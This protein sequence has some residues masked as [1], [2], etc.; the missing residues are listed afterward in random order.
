[1]KEV[2]RGKSVRPANLNEN[3]EWFD[4]NPLCDRQLGLI[5]F[6]LFVLFQVVLVA[7]LDGAFHGIDWV[8][9]MVPYYVFE[10]AEVTP[11]Y[12]IYTTNTYTCGI[13]NNKHLNTH[14]FTQCTKQHIF[15][16]TLMFVHNIRAHKNAHILMTFYHTY[17]YFQT[18]DD[19]ASKISET[20]HRSR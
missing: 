6:T 15:F 3:E 7:K 19:I 11:T 4:E 2:V 1:M 12:N 16:N 18:T 9:V 13:S 17:M 10:V 8:I 14:H 20:L 5:A